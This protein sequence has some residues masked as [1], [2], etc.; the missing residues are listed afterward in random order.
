MAS[1]RPVVV[2]WRVR[3]TPAAVG[4]TMNT[5]TPALDPF[6]ATHVAGARI[7]SA[8]SAAGT[9]ALVPVTLHDPSA[10]SVAVVAGAVPPG[11]MTSP[12]SSAMAAVRM[13]SPLV[14]PL[15]QV[16][17]WAL[18]PNRAIGRAP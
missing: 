1:G 11:R 9:H 5:P 8:T 4:S 10:C 3:V 18:V 16:L 13:I 6:A 2:L 12:A 15:S 14:T 17:R 7:A